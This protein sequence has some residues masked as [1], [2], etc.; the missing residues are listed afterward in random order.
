MGSTTDRPDGAEPRRT[1]AGRRRRA[2]AAVVVGATAAVLLAACGGDGPASVG[3]SEVVLRADGA[4]SPDGLMCAVVSEEAGRVVEGQ[5]WVLNPEGEPLVLQDVTVNSLKNAAVDVVGTGEGDFTGES[6]D[7]AA[8]LAQGAGDVLGRWPAS[9][10]DP[11]A[12]RPVEGVAVPA[13]S[14]VVVVA[15]VRL[16]DGARSG[17]FADVEVRGIRGG[18]PV[19]Q[20]FP[21]TLAA[22]PEGAGEDCES[23]EPLSAQP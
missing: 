11:E 23:A 4:A 17:G 8:Q 1:P 13:R 15:R 3:S 19:V 9:A 5:Y 14:G 21:A 7:V 6:A 18:L 16:D 20:R 2:A 22:V 10:P 12:V